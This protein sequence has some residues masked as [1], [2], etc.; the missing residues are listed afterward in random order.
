MALHPLPTP[1]LTKGEAEY[2]SYLGHTISCR[3][4]R[5]AGLC[6]AGRQLKMLWQATR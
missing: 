1:E 5:G 6:P 2:R 4:C 3:R